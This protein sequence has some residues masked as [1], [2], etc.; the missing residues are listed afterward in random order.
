MSRLV[1]FLGPPKNTQQ[2]HKYR[3]CQKCFLGKEG[4]PEY[5]RA[6]F[7]SAFTQFYLTPFICRQKTWK[8]ESGEKVVSD[9]ACKFQG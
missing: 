5:P 6:F 8:L 4:T 7:S 2:R 3:G 9:K 1:P